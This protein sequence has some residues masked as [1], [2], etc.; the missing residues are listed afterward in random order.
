[1][2]WHLH[3]IYEKLDVKSRTAAVARAHKLALL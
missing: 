3:N 1:M 2:K